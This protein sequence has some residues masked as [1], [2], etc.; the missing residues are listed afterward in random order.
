MVNVTERQVAAALEE[1]Q[2]VAVVTETSGD[3]QMYHGL[4][5]T[6]PDHDGESRPIPRSRRLG[7]AA[8]RFGSLGERLVNLLIA[9]GH[10]SAQGSTPQAPRT[11]TT[12]K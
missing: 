9:R 11:V 7:R 10:G 8:T 3:E 12:A 6:Q 2:L 5:R 1:V 4:E